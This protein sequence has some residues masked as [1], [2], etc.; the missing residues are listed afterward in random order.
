MKRLLAILSLATFISFAIA[1]CQAKNRNCDEQLGY[2][3]EDVLHTFNNDRNYVHDF[4]GSEEIYV[5]LN[6]A[7]LAYITLRRLGLVLD[8]KFESS[9]AKGYL[10][11]KAIKR[12]I[13]FDYDELKDQSE[14]I[15]SWI[16]LFGST[17]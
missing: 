11:H 8:K 4:V 12:E 3:N 1:S 13:L 2:V 10:I 7:R 5:A 14:F 9:D 17:I 15:L 6:D 16:S